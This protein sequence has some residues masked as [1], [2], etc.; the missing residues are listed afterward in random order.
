MEENIADTISI[1][2]ALGACED[3][4]S[5]LAQFQSLQ[6]AWQDWCSAAQMA[7]YAG[8][9]AEFSPEVRNRLARTLARFALEDVA[10]VSREGAELLRLVI[11]WSCPIRPVGEK[12]LARELLRRADILEQTATLSGD[13]ATI[14]ASVLVAAIVEVLLIA[15]STA[16]SAYEAAQ[17][18]L[19]LRLSLTDSEM[20]YA[21]RRQQLRQELLREFPVPPEIPRAARGIVTTEEA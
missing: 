14:H 18:T 10:R 7:T 2:R 12:P 1:L 20:K 13:T 8:V 19:L 16:A 9:C 4:L 5:A 3:A 15:G 21:Q 6:E 17:R 11:G